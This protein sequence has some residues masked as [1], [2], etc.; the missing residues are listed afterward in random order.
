MVRSVGIR[1]LK[2]S[3]SEYVRHVRAGDQV[4]VTDRGRVVAELRSP[5][6]SGEP[7]PYPALLERANRGGAR[8]GAPNQ[9]DIYPSLGPV[10]DGTLSSR[11]LDEQ[12]GDR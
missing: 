10:G 12:R 11:L 2:N 3:L 5:G 4:L 1:E 7:A 8:I 9:P 6:T